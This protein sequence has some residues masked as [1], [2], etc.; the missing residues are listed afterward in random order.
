MVFDLDAIVY[1]SLH[2]MSMPL[3]L[4]LFIAYKN[5]KHY[6]SIAYFALTLLF[7]SINSSYLA[8]IKKGDI[9][10]TANTIPCEIQAFFI[11]YLNSSAAIWPICIGSNMTLILLR[12]RRRQQKGGWSTKQLLLSFMVFSWGLPLFF[13]IAS[14]VM[15]IN[16]E[17]LKPWLYYCMLSEP[18]IGP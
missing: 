7:S 18:T 10:N 12:K 15:A 13:T 4:I 17:G 14:F 8:F 5:H 9:K 16:D 1:Y 2:I 11:T 3:S 6:P